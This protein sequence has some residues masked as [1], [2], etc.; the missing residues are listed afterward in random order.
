MMIAVTI[1]AA[2]WW[3]SVGNSRDEWLQDCVLKVSSGATMAEV[4]ELIGRKPDLQTT[5][6]VVLRE[7]MFLSPE[8]SR[9]TPADVPETL[10]IS[11][12][13]GGRRTLTVTF[14]L[15]G[16][17]RSRYLWSEPPGPPSVWSRVWN[18]IESAVSK[19]L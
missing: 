10:T 18:V 5:E 12:W 17:V 3:R 16:K 11:A 9:V 15:D 7:G 8:N 1:L 14:D 4:E 2:A 13:K 6:A 19:L